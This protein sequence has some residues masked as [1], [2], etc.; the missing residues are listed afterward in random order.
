[1]RCGSSSIPGRK[2]EPGIRPGRPLEATAPLAFH[3]EADDAPGRGRRG[4]GLA[5]AEQFREGVPPRFVVHGIPQRMH[6]L[7][8]GMSREQTREILGLEQT[9]LTGG[10]DARF[11]YG[12]GNGHD[13]H[14]VYYIRPPRIVA[15]MMRHVGGGHPAPIGGPRIEGDDPALI[16]DGFRVVDRE[17]AGGQA[18][19]TR[20]GLPL[21][22]LQ[23]DCRDAELEIKRRNR[24]RAFPAWYD[25]LRAPGWPGPAGCSW[26]S[27]G[28]RICGWLS[29]RTSGPVSSSSPML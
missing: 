22:R 16:Q 25:A 12:E 9:W 19:A 26:P 5:I 1:M 23:D 29:L 18:H 8:P 15:R 14:E 7:R 27:S 24:R 3:G 20:P 6:R 2:S 17:S 13:Q 21:L 11:A 10:T 28:R 4:L